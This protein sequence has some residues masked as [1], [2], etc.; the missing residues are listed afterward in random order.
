MFGV[1]LYKNTDSR[2]LFV[3][4]VAMPLEKSNVVFFTTSVI[5]CYCRHLSGMDASNLFAGSFGFVFGLFW[6]FSLY[7]LWFRVHNNL[8]WALFMV[9]VLS[10]A[11]TM[12]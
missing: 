8:L 5:Y 1:K 7:Q 2:R 10:G 3:Y 4:K 6:F 11:P 9:Q 12:F